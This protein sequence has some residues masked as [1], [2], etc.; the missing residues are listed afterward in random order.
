MPEE[1]AVKGEETKT[2]EKKKSKGLPP[3]AMLG[4]IIVVQLVAAWAVAQF[5]I[6]PRLGGESV[7]ETNTTT[8]T[9]GEIFLMDDLVVTL[10][11]ED[12]TRFLKISPGLECENAGVQA[13]LEERMPEIRDM[14]I[15]TLS[16]MSLAEAVASEGREAMK[17]RLLSE[18]NGTLTKGKLLNIYFSDYMV[19]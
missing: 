6:L 15:C 5:M 9:R 13:E 2:S 11:T 18:L 7:T 8:A 17:I 12:G 10:G 16:G 4:A 1:E 3:F 14:L 19:Q